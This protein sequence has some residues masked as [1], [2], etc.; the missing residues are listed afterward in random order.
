MKLQKIIQAGILTLALSPV[1]AFAQTTAVPAGTSEFGATTQVPSYVLLAPIPCLGTNG[2]TD[3]GTTCVNGQVT[4]TSIQGY[5]IYVFKLIIALAVLL[6]IIMT[7]WGGFKYMT[8]ESVTGK[9]GARKTIQ[10]AVT[11][12]L[13]ALASYLILYTINPNLVNLANVN[14]PKLNVK[15][16]PAITDTL[17]AVNTQIQQASQVATTN[18][19]NANAQAA[20]NLQT[21]QSNAAQIQDQI[22]ACDAGITA[23]DPITY[24]GLQDELASAQQDIVAQTNQSTTQTTL[25]K[26]ISM[27]QLDTG[28]IVSSAVSNTDAMVKIQSDLSTLQKNY[29]AAVSALGNDAT[30][31]QILQN[32]Y[33][34]SFATLNN[35]LTLTQIKAG[36]VNSND[37]LAAIKQ[38]DTLM[39][40]NADPALQKQYTALTTQI[41]TTVDGIINADQTGATTMQSFGGN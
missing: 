18:A 26:M 4:S 8:V 12:L 31:V 32:Q 2:S 37:A 35:E 17:A 21:A 22:D 40:E 36:I 38:Q 23:C 29:Y 5:L 6:A 14:V 3:P 41:K 7:I 25:G 30:D 20:L 13:L 24:Q 10:D 1:A 34:Y 16:N 11:G 28:N 9:S 19:I 27:T 39:S 15:V 33:A